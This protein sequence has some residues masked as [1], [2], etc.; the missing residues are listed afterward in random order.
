MNYANDFLNVSQKRRSMAINKMLVNNNIQQLNYF[1][2]NEKMFKI[3][4]NIFF[5][6]FASIVSSPL[7]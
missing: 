4:N 3:T 5:H 6:D 1:N 2:N 7:Y